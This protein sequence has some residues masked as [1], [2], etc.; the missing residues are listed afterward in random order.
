MWRIRKLVNTPTGN[1]LLINHL[2]MITSKYYPVKTK[3]QAVQY[4]QV[5]LLSEEQACH[6]YHI[7]SK[8]LHQWMRWHEKFFVQPQWRPPHNNLDIMAQKKSKTKADLKDKQKIKELE[9]QL[10]LMKKEN[11]L[12][13]LKAE[14]YKTMI[15]VA[16]EHFNIKIGKKSGAK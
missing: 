2:S 1:S 13:Q 7:S 5:G 4:V 14:A 15:E 16:E 10:K 9:K 11:E 3:K 12:A 6:K 8:L